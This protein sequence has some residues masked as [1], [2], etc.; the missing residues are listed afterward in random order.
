MFKN[1][2]IE[3]NSERLSIN[4]KNEN[5]ILKLKTESQKECNTASEAEFYWHKCQEIIKDNVSAQ[6][7]KTWFEPIKALQFDNGKLVVSV[8][9]QF[10]CEWIEEHYYPLLRR[11]VSEAMGENATLQY[12]VVV[13]ESAVNSKNKSIK[14]P[15]FKYPPQNKQV[16][17]QFNQEKPA[18]EEFI[19]YLNPRY[20]FDNFIRGESNQLASSAATAVSQ[21]PGKTR[22][23]PLVIYGET[24]LGKTHLVQGIGNQIIHNNSRSRVLYTTSERFTME[25]VNAIQNNKTSEFIQFYRNIDVLIVDDIQFFGGKEKTQD[26]FF[27][28]FNALHQAGKQIILTSDRPPRDLSEVDDRLISRFQWGLIVDVQPPDLEMRMAILQKKSADEGFELPNDVVEYI[29][30]YV[31]SSVRE[32]EGA[33]ISLIAKVTFD[34]REMNL[35]LAKE[36][37]HGIANFE[38]KPVTT[39]DIKQLVAD[40]YKLTPEILES[41]SRKHEI[42]LARQLAMYL[43]KEF[44]QLSLKSIGSTFGGRDHSTVMHSCQAIENYLI[45]DRSVKAAYDYLCK[46]MKKHER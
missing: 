3:K 36:V 18:E 46:K 22:F 19:T 9:S 7:W 17:L 15:A 10:F 34:G 1:S 27:H 24:G 26:N 6:V 28:T 4:V 35:D 2:D 21:N 30:R 43:S 44:T 5:N 12:E 8:P 40:Y 41:K 13:D 14:L 31:N 23:N 32:L 45:T 42:T 37:V 11:T 39:D 33:L 38:P 20:V 16:A 25:F 29:A